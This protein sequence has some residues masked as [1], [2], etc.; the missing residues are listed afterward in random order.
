MDVP[1]DEGVLIL[2]ISTGSP[3]DQ[4]GLRGG[5]EQVRIGRTILLVGGDIVTA[6]DGEPMGTDRDLLRFLDTQTQ[7]GQTIQIYD[8]TLTTN[9]NVAASVVSSVTAADPISSTQTITVDNV[10]SGTS[11]NDLIVHDGLTGASPVSLFGIKYH[12]NNAPTGTWLNLNR[13]TYPQQ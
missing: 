13:A 6:I 12:Q 2:E 1:V 11:V 5:Q 8:P 3:A 9:R 10:P 4:A 7:V